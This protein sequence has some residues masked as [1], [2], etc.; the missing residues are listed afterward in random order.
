MNTSRLLT[1][2]NQMHQRECSVASDTVFSLTCGRKRSALSACG[3]QSASPRVLAAIEAALA[4]GDADVRE[5][6]VEAC[7]RLGAREAVVR[8]ATPDSLLY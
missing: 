5:A 8:S 4:H 7:G 3:P 2:Q 1:L 6:A